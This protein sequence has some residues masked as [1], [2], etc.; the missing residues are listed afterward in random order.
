MFA[1]HPGDRDLESVS[2]SRQSSFL[3]LPEP[4]MW[5][6]GTTCLL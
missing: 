6:L 4:I 5:T 2:D 1:R 3:A